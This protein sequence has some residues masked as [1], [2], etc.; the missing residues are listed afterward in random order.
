VTRSRH[1]M[2]LYC[3]LLATSQSPST[4]ICQYKMVRHEVALTE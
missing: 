3:R 1:A 4:P 2:L